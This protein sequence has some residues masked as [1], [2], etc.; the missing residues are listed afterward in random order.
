MKKNIILGS[1]LIILGLLIAVGPQTIF[2]VCGAKANT[3]KS[4]SM[5]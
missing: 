3:E 5:S 1:I 2:P 4:Q